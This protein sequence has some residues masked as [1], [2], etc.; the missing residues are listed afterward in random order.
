MRR[1]AAAGRL[2]VGEQRAVDVLHAAGTGAVMTLLALP[3]QERDPAL[4]DVLWSAA[5]GAVLVGPAVPT[6]QA[7][8]D[9]GG[10]PVAAAVAL[11]ASLPGLAALSPGERGLMA[12]WLD[13]VVGATPERGR[14]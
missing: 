14:R 2:R 9:A 11:R 1:V 5:A 6:G 13:R 12:E 3:P 7:A 4:A 10:G 8:D